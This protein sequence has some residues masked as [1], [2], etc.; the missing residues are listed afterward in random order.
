MEKNK[1]FIIRIRSKEKTEYYIVFH[2]VVKCECFSNF[3]ERCMCA[4]WEGFLDRYEK[5]SWASYWYDSNWIFNHTLKIHVGLVD[6][7]K[8]FFFS[9]YKTHFNTIMNFA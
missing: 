6:F 3:G 2:Y 4:G 5:L 1:L 9:F 8:V 7:S